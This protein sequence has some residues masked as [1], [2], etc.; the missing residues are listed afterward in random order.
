[1]VL[2]LLQKEV[3]EVGQVALEAASQGDDLLLVLV[4][5]PLE[6]LLGYFELLGEPILKLLAHTIELPAV[7][8]L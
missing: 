5:N 2:L 6:L 8:P 4:E 1:M 3:V 7:A